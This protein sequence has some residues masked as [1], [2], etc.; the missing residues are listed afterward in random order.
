M[1]EKVV[2]ATG[3]VVLTLWT[4]AALTKEISLRPS[5]S[6]LV[7][8][9]LASFQTN[10]VP[11]LLLSFVVMYLHV[12][13]AVSFITVSFASYV[14]GQY[15]QWTCSAINTALQITKYNFSYFGSH[16]QFQIRTGAVKRP[17]SIN[18]AF[19]KRPFFNFF[20]RLIRIWTVN[21]ETFSWLFCIF[22]IH[23]LHL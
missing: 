8:G 18:F 2:R 16:L 19:F 1:P 5:F 9:H 23:M 4:R 10:S 15:I 11:L 14:N 7:Q 6:L 21:C 3:Y 12:H 22:L 13:L 17:S 20:G